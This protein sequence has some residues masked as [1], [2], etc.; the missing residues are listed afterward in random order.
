MVVGNESDRATEAVPDSLAGALISLGYVTEERLQRA[1]REAAVLLLL[2]EY[3]AFGLPVIEAL[4][5]ATPVVMTDQP[6][7]ASL[8]REEEGVHF[9]D[10]DD[11]DAVAR[12]VG[13]LISDGPAV[14]ERL[15]RRRV[16]LAQIYSWDAA[17][18]R[19]RDHLR[20][21]WARRCRVAGGY[22]PI[23]ASASA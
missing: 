9:V 13:R 6:A 16:E 17:A 2:S 10:G 21:A 5:S 20:A 1:Y 18:R 12:L 11:L 3:E 7:P 19:T 22:L 23:A 15:G 14:R 4:A 8:F